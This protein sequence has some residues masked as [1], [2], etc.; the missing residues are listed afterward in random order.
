MTTRS[1]LGM[2]LLG[3]LLCGLV[4]SGCVV[5]GGS[6]SESS[7]GSGFFFL[8]LPLIGVLLL[9]A[10]FRR[11][12]RRWSSEQRAVGPEASPH[13]LRAELSVLAD[14]VLR[15]EPQVVL[16]PSARDDYEAA[17]HRY[18][19]AQSALEEPELPVDL[20]RVQRVVDEATWL[21]ARARAIIDGR[22][23]PDP[24]TRLQ[25]QGPTGEPAVQLDDQERPTYIG[26]PVSF[27]AGWFGFGGGMFGGL[28]GGAVLGPFDDW[29]TEA[30]ESAD[31]YDEGSESY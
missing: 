23:P 4:L 18:R 10:S 19:V 22:K 15:L 14:D 7:G 29:E 21:M 12:R 24:P 8:L 27:N 6:R 9:A 30:P 1:V 2:R 5:V 31:G 17:L 3:S 26:V 25:R 20:S 13:M 11:R 28:L 16:H